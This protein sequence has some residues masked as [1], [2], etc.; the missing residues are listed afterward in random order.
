LPDLSHPAEQRR[1]RQALHEDRRGDD[2]K[3]DRDN[4]FAPRD[5]GGLS[6]ATGDCFAAASGS[7][8]CTGGRVGLACVKGIA[9]ALAKPAVRISSLQALATFGRFS[10]RAPVLDA[11]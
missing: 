2:G 8:S 7:G 3:T 4:L 9:E 10:L 6:I 1:D 11:R 5:L